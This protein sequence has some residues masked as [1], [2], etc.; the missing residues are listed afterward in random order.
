MPA[1]PDPELASRLAKAIV[2]LYGEA[3]SKL[4]AAVARRIAVGIDEPGWAERKLAQLDQLRQ[5]AVAEVRRLDEALTGAVTGAVEQGAEAGAAQ[6]LRDLRAAGATADLTS[7]FIGVQ[8]HAIAAL[9]EQTVGS[10]RITHLQLLRSTLDAYRAAVAEASGQVVV[11][12]ATRLQAAQSA[13]DRF[14]QSGVS[15][16]VDTAG[17]SWSIE[18]YAEMATRTAVGR[19]QVQGALDRFS[20]AGYDLVIVSDASGECELCRPWEGQILSQ[21][22]DT[23]GYPTVI[24][25][26][27]SGLFHANCRHGLGLYVPGVTEPLVDTAD[28][29][30]DAARQ[31]Q[32]YLERGVRQ[33][34]RRQAVALDDSAAAQAK[35][36]VGE[37]QGRLREH[38]AANDLMRQPQRER[39]GAR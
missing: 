32:R 5:E 18:T 31:Q 2:D 9:I 33:W 8:R 14:A 17:R 26:T 37:W 21:T 34:K 36:K 19:A 4:L 1:R 15:G 29:E 16:F 12:A 35:A 20:D 25:A 39:L 24:D 10:I 30:G 6:A 23:P 22:G 7:G 11:G 27:A 13:L 28:P 3:T 38:V